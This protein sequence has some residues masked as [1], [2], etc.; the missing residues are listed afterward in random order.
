MGGY[1]FS[2]LGAS[3]REERYNPFMLFRH[4]SSQIKRGERKAS[5]SRLLDSL[6]VG[7]SP[8]EAVGLVKEW[9]IT[10]QEPVGRFSRERRSPG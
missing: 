3:F 8:G 10:I 2:G 1:Q 5:G 9:Q 4:E 6:M 7:R